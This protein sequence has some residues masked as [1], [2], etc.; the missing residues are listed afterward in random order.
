MPYRDPYQGGWAR[1]LGQAGAN[2]SGMI[3]R[4][5]V[6]KRARQDERIAA[7]AERAKRTGDV[8]EWLGAMEEFGPKDVNQ[9]AQ[10]HG[11][12]RTITPGDS[13]IAALPAPQLTP[14]M[15]EKGGPG[16]D[17]QK[18]VTLQDLPGFELKAP[19]SGNEVEPPTL[20]PE[21]LMSGAPTKVTKQSEL[22]PSEPYE[23]PLPSTAEGLGVRATHEKQRTGVTSEW[24]K[25]KMTPVDAVG[26]LQSMAKST[27]DT[28]EAEDAFLEKYTP[29]VQEWTEGEIPAMPYSTGPE[30]MPASEAIAKGAAIQQDPL[31]TPEA[32]EQYLTALESE[33]GTKLTRG[34]AKMTGIKGIDTMQG[35]AEGIE[36]LGQLQKVYNEVKPR[37]EKL[38]GEEL[39]PV[40]VFQTIKPEATFSETFALLR[41]IDLEP[42]ELATF[43]KTRKI[44][45]RMAKAIQTERAKAMEPTTSLSQLASLFAG[46]PD[47]D[48]A[49][50]YWRENKGRVPPATLAKVGPAGTAEITKA[51]FDIAKDVSEVYSPNELE[52]KGLDSIG[53]ITTAIN[54][55]TFDMKEYADRSSQTEQLNK[56][57]DKLTGKFI[58]AKKGTTI[59]SKALKVGG[60]FTETQEAQLKETNKN[61]WIPLLL[62]WPRTGSAKKKGTTSEDD[63]SVME[64][65]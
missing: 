40:E 27:T 6:R 46:G 25:Q 63:L 52:K 49:F 32:A 26:L 5:N 29:I 51:Q 48:V 8:S 64:N 60:I 9:Y 58:T 59:I 35:F 39:P 47:W 1:T 20:Q 50:K 57:L 31:V 3:E 55:G 45:P 62:S 41:T 15:L 44:T 16:E 54:D 38:T 36:D 17:L 28:K 19:E 61:K 18:P 42:G 24:A 22:T 11:L 30:P 10:L 53:D 56:L 4:A 21:M 65:K 13:A 33:S 43:S 7:V 37:I 2:I 23:V 12:T 34:G 14:I